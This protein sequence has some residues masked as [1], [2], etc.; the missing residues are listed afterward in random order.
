[1]YGYRRDTSPNLDQFAAGATVFERAYTHSPW[2]AP[3]IASILTAL[4]PRD[5][6]ITSWREALSEEHLTLAEHLRAS[7]YQTEA[8]IS[9]QILTERYQFNQGFNEYNSSVFSE[10]HPHDISSAGQ[11]TDLA[12]ECLDQRPRDR[13]LFLWL[14]YFDPHAEYI[15]HPGFDFGEEERIDLY[16]S[17]LA[18]TDHH[19]GRLLDHLAASGLDEDTVV[20]IIGDHGEEFLDH[21][22][23]QHSNQLFEEVMRVPL[24]IDAPGLEAGRVSAVVPESD[25][26][27]TLLSLAG[28]DIPDAFHGAAMPVTKGRLA[29]QDRPVFMETFRYADKRGVVESDWK[30]VQDLKA[31]RVSLYNLREDPLEKNDVADDYPEVRERLLVSLGAHYSETRAEVEAQDLSEA[32]IERL[33]ALGYI[34]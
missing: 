11:V 5:H 25:L 9:H 14:H 31:D 30:V 7:G 12:I 33:R 15:A 13:P 28:L 4:P 1:M 21:G 18:W 10:G 19:L 8:I 17:E 32:E 6:G 26:A 22:S 34:E 2:T 24:I 29:P 16:D 23:W 3:S 27:P 20:A